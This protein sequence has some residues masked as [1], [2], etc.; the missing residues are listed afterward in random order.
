MISKLQNSHPK[1][2][3]MK[4]VIL[5]FGLP[6]QVPV[7]SIAS[8]PFCSEKCRGLDDTFYGHPICQIFAVSHCPWDFSNYIVIYGSCRWPVS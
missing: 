4:K 1:T 2:E 8:A 3:F 5:G 7:L 6:V